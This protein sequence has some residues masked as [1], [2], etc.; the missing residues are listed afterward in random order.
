MSECHL[1]P[2]SDVYPNFRRHY[3]E[4][5]E[6]KVLSKLDLAKGFYQ[7]VMEDKSIEL[8]TFVSPY[9]KYQFRRMPFGLKN[10][11]A[12]F[13]A[14][15]ERVL[16]QCRMLLSIYSYCHAYFCSSASR[17]AVYRKY[18][19]KFCIVLLGSTTVQILE[20]LL[21]FYSKLWHKIGS[22]VEISEPQ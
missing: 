16:D 10:A 21:R 8:T 3:R 12:T 4:G 22:R 6:S 14:L 18:G 5:R 19:S 2:A 13:Q 20:P 1:S 7:V 15:M 17:C 11:P 9:G